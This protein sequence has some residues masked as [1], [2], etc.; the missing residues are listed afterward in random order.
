MEPIILTLLFV[1]TLIGGGVYMSV[2]LYKHGVVGTKRQTLTGASAIE[3][4][5]DDD[6]FYMTMST[7]AGTTSRYA[8][9][10]LMFLLTSVGFFVMLLALMINSIAH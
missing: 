7:T 4:A 2:Y 8:R 10:A 5:S 1:G 6:Q 3:E 9:N